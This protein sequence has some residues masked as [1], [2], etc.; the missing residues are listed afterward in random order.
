MIVNYD[1]NPNLTVDQKLQS[2]LE[3]IQMALNEI[4]T[5]HYTKA[6]TD[7]LLKEIRDLVSDI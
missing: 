3:S 2:L 6:E 1:K 4:K 5:E 7:K